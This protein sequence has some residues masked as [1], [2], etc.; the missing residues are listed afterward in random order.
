V[1]LSIFHDTS[2]KFAIHAC[3]SFFFV[4][5]LRQ[6]QWQP[7]RGALMSVAPYQFFSCF[8]RCV[9]Q[10]LRRQ[11]LFKRSKRYAALLSC[12]KWK[13]CSTEALLQALLDNDV[14]ESV[15]QRCLIAS[16]QN[17]GSNWQVST[18]VGGYGSKWYNW[19]YWWNLEAKAT[20]E[21]N[22]AA[23]EATA[24]G[25]TARAISAD[26]AAVVANTDKD[27]STVAS[28]MVAAGNSSFNR[29][30][31]SDLG[32]VGKLLVEVDGVGHL[33]M[34]FK[35]ITSHNGEECLYNAPTSC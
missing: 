10:Q 35:L 4:C 1:D 8:G 7:F 30:D 11:S 19:L 16:V 15:M 22:G 27:L 12:S 3:V 25:A 31:G 13:W 23:A 6:S 32:A 24:E 29:H 2:Q 26:V 20:A 21:S 17:L 18:T 14:A 5:L 34:S 33:D 28:A 9:R